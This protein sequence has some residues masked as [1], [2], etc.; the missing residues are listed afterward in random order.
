MPSTATRPGGHRVT[1]YGGYDG[2]PLPAWVPVPAKAGPASDWAPGTGLALGPT[3]V[4]ASAARGM[5]IEAI[6]R[7]SLGADAVELVTL[8]LSEIVTNAATAAARLTVPPTVR[9]WIRPRLD[10]RAVLVT[11]WDAGPEVPVLRDAVAADDVECGRGLL[12]VD[13]ESA[14]WGWEPWPAPPLGVPGKSV[15]CVIHCG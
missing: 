7:W 5:A 15:W 3:P 13:K 10:M 14:A 11:V 6:R 1:G 8:L 12:I 2:P 4:A 9:V